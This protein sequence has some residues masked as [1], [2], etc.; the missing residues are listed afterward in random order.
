MNLKQVESQSQCTSQM[1]SLI[2]QI[3]MQQ[4]KIVSLEGAQIIYLILFNFQYNLYS[5]G[6]H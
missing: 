4:E 6:S 3:S 1:R 5:V 2:D